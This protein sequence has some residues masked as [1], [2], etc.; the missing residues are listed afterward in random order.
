MISYT[1]AGDEN[2]ISPGGRVMKKKYKVLQYI[3]YCLGEIHDYKPFIFIHVIV[4]TI[5]TVAI[6]LMN[7]LVPTLIVAMLA[8]QVRLG[9]FLLHLLLMALGLSL[10]RIAGQENLL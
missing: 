10:F 5:T 3:K 8:S 9:D 6:A 1:F 2:M 4:Y 7:V